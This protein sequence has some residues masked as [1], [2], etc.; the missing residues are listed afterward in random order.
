MSFCLDIKGR[1]RGDE[2]NGH[3]PDMKPGVSSKPLCHDQVARSMLAI[4]GL[5]HINALESDH[6][7]EQGSPRFWVE[8]RRQRNHSYWFSFPIP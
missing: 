5:I 4:A 7:H 1:H 3:F 8:R 2:M 6:C